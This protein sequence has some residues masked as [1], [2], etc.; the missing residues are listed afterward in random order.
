MSEHMY[1][2]EFTSQFKKGLKQIKKQG[3]DLTK[4]EQVIDMLAKGE[5]LPEKY[6]D[7]EL[8]GNWAHHRECHVEPD[9]FLVYFYR[10]DVLV[11]TLAATGSH[12]D[13]F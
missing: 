7:H 3:R 5:L 12:S 10:D 2:I 8:K 1:E 11:L 6:H 4:L 13:L 9:W